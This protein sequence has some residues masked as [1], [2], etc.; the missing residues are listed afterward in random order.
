ML[1]ERDCSLFLARVAVGGYSP[2]PA[3][4]PAC[5]NGLLRNLDERLEM[6]RN[7]LNEGCCSVDLNVN[8]K[9]ESSDKG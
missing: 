1:C 7:V 2:P 8:L 9:V 5:L 3:V 6:R 4:L